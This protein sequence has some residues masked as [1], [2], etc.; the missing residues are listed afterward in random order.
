MLP[1]YINVPLQ[2]VWG[3]NRALHTDIA[4]VLYSQTVEMFSHEGLH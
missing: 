1:E 2:L 3:V 4:L